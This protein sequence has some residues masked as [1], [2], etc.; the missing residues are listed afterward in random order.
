MYSVIHADL[1]NEGEFFVVVPMDLCQ[2]HFINSHML[3]QI[4]GS[5]PGS[6]LRLAFIFCRNDD[7][8]LEARRSIVI[9]THRTV[10]DMA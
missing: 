3:Q 5:F 7:R 10:E 1:V 2:L 9:A 4:C 6:L 8:S